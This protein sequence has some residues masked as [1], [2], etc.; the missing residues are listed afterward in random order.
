MND[1]FVGFEHELSFD[2]K[3]EQFFVKSA[4]RYQMDSF[5]LNDD[6]RNE[7]NS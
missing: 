4:N 6:D 2:V 3:N 7:V 5:G 1:P